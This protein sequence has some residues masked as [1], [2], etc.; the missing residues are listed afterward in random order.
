[1]IDAG[2]PDGPPADALDID[3]GPRGVDGADPCGARRD[4]GADEFAV[5]LDCD[6]PETFLVRHPR[7][8]TRD[9]TPSFR[10]RS[11]EPGAV[12]ECKL[13]HHPF[14]PCPASVTFGRQRHGRHRLLARASDRR[15][16]VDPTP[17]RFDFRIRR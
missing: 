3:G 14:R 4:I 16:N 6:P 10:F 2:K 17:V 11:D 5:V 8:R 15:G 1:M 9:R 12:F 7:K 13:D